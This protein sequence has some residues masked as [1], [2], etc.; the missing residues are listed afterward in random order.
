MSIYGYL[1]GCQPDWNL[2]G[3]LSALSLSYTESFR[4]RRAN[5]AGVADEALH[6][7]TGP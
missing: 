6:N 7:A 1:H 3:G 2:G 5:P 4:A